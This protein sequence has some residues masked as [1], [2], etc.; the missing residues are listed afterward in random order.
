MLLVV[1]MARARESLIDLDATP[2]YHCINRCIRR[3]YLC[4]DD[5]LC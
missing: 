5:N 4:G 3:S 2:Y 1:I